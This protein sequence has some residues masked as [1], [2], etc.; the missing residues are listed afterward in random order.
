MQFNSNVLRTN[1]INSNLQLQIGIFYLLHFLTNLTNSKS[2]IALTQLFFQ[3]NGKNVRGAL[4]FFRASLIVIIKYDVWGAMSTYFWAQ[5]V[6]GQ[7]LLTLIS[8]ILIWTSFKS[9][10]RDV[11]EAAEN[12]NN[13]RWVI[14]KSYLSLLQIVLRGI[15]F[16]INNL[17]FDFLKDINYSR[18]IR[19]FVNAQKLY[20]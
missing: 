4:K 20:V 10:W 7:H 5:Y 9:D 16:L 15:F 2:S 17:S 14:Y 1:N 11:L 8:K 18:C 13:F 19:F 6:C 3:E 12:V